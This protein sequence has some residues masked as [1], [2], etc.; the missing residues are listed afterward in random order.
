MQGQSEGE[1]EEQRKSHDRTACSR[2]SL[3]P[4]SEVAQAVQRAHT[5]D[6]VYRAVSDRVAGLGYSAAVFT[7]TYDRTYLAPVYWRDFT[8]HG[9]LGTVSFSGLHPVR[10]LSVVWVTPR[11]NATLTQCPCKTNLRNSHPVLHC[12]SVL[13]LLNVTE[14]R[15]VH[16][17]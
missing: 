12:S 1:Q 8:R 4:L 17:C 9:G 13:C 14:G 7:L 11:P 16:G 3:L 5:P 15:H 2:D 10:P 6:E